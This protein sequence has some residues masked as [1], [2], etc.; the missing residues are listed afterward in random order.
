M[1]I[2]GSIEFVVFSI[3]TIIL[4]NLE[5]ELFEVSFYNLIYLIFYSI[6]AFCLMKTIYI[7]NSQYVS[8]LVISETVGSTI[9]MFIELGIDILSFCKGVIP[10]VLVKYQT[11]EIL[12]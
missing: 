12:M 1:V 5:I 10:L 9:V 11:I 4:I 2:R 6:K 3:I 8:F 7:F